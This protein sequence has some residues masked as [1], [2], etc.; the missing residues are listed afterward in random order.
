MILL[1]SS[2][3]D[4]PSLLLGHEAIASGGAVLAPSS[5]ADPG[6]APSTSMVFNAGRIWNGTFVRHVFLVENTGSEDLEIRDVIEGEGVRVAGFTR[7]IPALE[8]GEVVLEVSTRRLKGDIK[9]TARVFFA[10]PQR[11]ALDLIITGVVATGVELAPD[12][13][14]RFKTDQGKALSWHFKVTSPRKKDFMISR[15][16]PSTPY[17]E[18]QY[19]LLEKGRDKGQGN[20]FDLEIR[21]SP[22][23]PAGKFKGMVKV[24]TDI[25]GS[26]PGEAFFTG[27][28]LG[29]VMVRPVH[30]KF[31]GQEDGSFSPAR[32][33]FSNRKGDPFKVT[34][35]EAD[36]PGIQWKETSLKQG[37]VHRLDLSWKGSP[38]GKLQ[39]GKLVVLTDIADQK[40]IEVPYVVFP[41]MDCMGAAKA[42]VHP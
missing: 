9:K 30:I 28:V 15:I 5:M 14:V 24:K 16:E 1:C 39:N 27:E 26:Y 4:T 3:P 40:Q 6:P 7:K 33:S 42:A 32:I 36:T 21:L 13:A 18:S 37:R 10:R 17:L 29:P 22:D 25:A 8:K 31:A 35:V 11:P 12:N 34:G 41:F 20:T 23:T 38:A 19:R 2:C